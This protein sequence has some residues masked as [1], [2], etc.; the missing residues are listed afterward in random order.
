MPYKNSGSCLRARRLCKPTLAA[1]RDGK[2]AS[3]TMGKGGYNTER[4]C[5]KMIEVTISLST[6][7]SVLAALAIWDG[8]KSAV[9]KA[10]RRKVKED[11]DPHEEDTQRAQ[12]RM[13]EGFNN[14]MSYDMDTARSAARGDMS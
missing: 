3:E 5:R 9:H 11:T 10:A 4:V 2:G 14:L 6:M 8:V 7:L 12:E 1:G 13:L